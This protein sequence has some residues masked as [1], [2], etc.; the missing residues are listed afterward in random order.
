MRLRLSPADIPAEQNRLKKFNFNSAFTAARPHKRSEKA[1]GTALLARSRLAPTVLVSSRHPLPDGELPWDWTAIQVPF[2]GFFLIC[3]VAY[4]TAGVGCKAENLQK[5]RQITRLLTLTVLPWVLFADWNFSPDALSKSGAFDLLNC[6]LLK[7][8]GVEVTCRAGKG[9]LLDYAMAA[10]NAQWLLGDLNPVICPWKTHLGLE[11]AVT[12]K[13]QQLQIRKLRAPKNFDLPILA[14]KV[15]TQLLETLR[16]RISWENAERHSE[17]YL[18]QN[19][20]EVPGF[21]KNTLAL[22]LSGEQ[23]LIFGQEYRRWMT[24]MEVILQLVGGVPCDVTDDEQD[25]EEEHQALTTLKGIEKADKVLQ[26][27][28]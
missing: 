23:A 24:T 16:T 8:Q 18:L 7:P 11:I 10:S 14:K 28:P 25:L 17:A 21:I 5:L 1:G 20:C 4:M 22:E 3:I 27:A 15:R 26:M 13:P 19:P 9:A 6:S 12:R 2:A